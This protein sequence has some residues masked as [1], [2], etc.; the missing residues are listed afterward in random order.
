MLAGRLEGAEP[1]GWSGDSATVRDHL[2]NKTLARLRGQELS[3]KATYGLLSYLK[4]MPAPP[5]ASSLDDDRVRR[6]KAIFHSADS[7]CASCHGTERFADGDRHDVQ[8]QSPLDVAA[9]FDTPSLKFVAGTAPYF[10][11]GRFPTL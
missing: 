8:S 2:Q 3:P 1:F 7:G 6:G 11:D 9:E 10:H 5:R 4:F